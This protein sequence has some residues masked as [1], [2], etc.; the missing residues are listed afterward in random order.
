[1]NFSQEQQDAITRHGQDACCVAGPGS[2]KTTV[3]VERFAW[4]IQQGLDPSTILAITF[5]EKAA[6]QIKAR[7]IK[8]FRDDRD[9]R[10]AVERAQVST[11]HAFCLGLL[12]DNAL[13]AGLDPA[14]TV[15][16]EREAIAEQS[17]A[18]DLV[19]DRLAAERQPE[20]AAC[21]EAWPPHDLSS[22][23]RAVFENLRMAGGARRAL[24]QLASFDPQSELDSFEAELRAILADAPPPKSEPQRN[25]ITAAYAWLDARPATHPLLWISSFKIDLQGLRTGHPVYDGVQRLRARQPSVAGA[26]A[27]ALHLPQR[28][29]LRDALIEFEAEYDRRK[30]LSARLDFEDLQERALALLE[31]DSHFR[32]ETQSRFSAI[33]MDELQDTNPIQWRILDAVRTPGRF[34]A[35]GDINQSIYGFRHAAPE[36]F[37]AYEASIASSGGTIDRLQDNYRSRKPILDAVTAITVTQP[38][39]GILSHKLRAQRSLPEAN[40]PFLEIQRVETKDGNDEF[41]WL[42]R[43]LRECHGTPVGDPPRPARYQDMAILARSNAVFGAIQEALAL[44]SIPCIVTRGRNFFEAPEVLDLTNWLRVLENPSNEIALFSLL[45]SPFF[46]IGDEEITRLRLQGGLAP[47]HAWQR[48]QLARRL[49]EDIPADRILAGL[50]DESG[51]LAKLAPGGVANV[52]KFL[53]LLRQLD[54][55]SPGDLATHL[56]HIGDLRATG[57]EPHARETDARDAVEIL[58]IHS[59][60]GLEFP[61]VALAAMHRRSGGSDPF[62]CYSP[63]S[64][65]GVRWRIPGASESVPDS[66]FLAHSSALSE[67]ER[68][69]EDRLLYVAMTRAEERLLLSY[70]FTKSAR[71][72]WVA[73]I[74]TGLGIDWPAD[75]SPFESGSIRARKLS[76]LPE[77]LDPVAATEETRVTNIRPLPSPT[78]AAAGLSVTA[79]SVFDACPRRYFLQSAVGWPQPAAQKGSGAMALGTEVHEFLGGLREEISP[80]ARALAA[81]F[82]QSDLGRRA[83]SASRAEREMDFLV[84]LQGALL[85]GQIDLWFEEPGGAVLVDYK[86]DQHLSEARLRA[87]SLQL[88]LYAAAIERL[89]GRAPREAWLF[90]LRD[91]HSH[92][93]DVTPD[94]RNAA[95]RILDAWREA[96]FRGHFPTNPTAE[97]RWCPYLNGACP[98][99]QPQ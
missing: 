51:Y 47:A 21:V 75:G 86:T 71:N 74:E 55:V 43:R 58:S 73:M 70:T 49:R 89:T 90:S 46:G 24:H 38:A 57:K 29:F 91:G 88:R 83:A 35:V 19:L 27:G 18:M 44:F 68:R 98:V 8:R 13:K 16:D 54:A 34:F 60:K 78:A 41:L 14:F 11:I 42:A 76:G 23:L 30:R 94:A 61:I 7:L 26:V 28:A 39:A 17:A 99:S 92:S 36:A 66:V 6:T 59:A 31:S 82:E 64:G 56:Q 77:I 48:I 1:M 2:G 96:E 3:L 25:R 52:E 20:F 81:V 67:S 37:S 10:R 95:L 62:L 53:R 79:L 9:K 65:L 15:M 63:Q 69:E 97:C 45:R 72:P 4:L 40:G 22:A 80:E 32:R 85:R 87:Y 50:I 93:V 33:L 12:R 84:E 5:T